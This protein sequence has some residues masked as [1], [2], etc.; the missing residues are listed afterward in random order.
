MLTYSEWKKAEK[1]G[2][3]YEVSEPYL[4]ARKWCVLVFIAPMKC[5]EYELDEIKE[6]LT[7]YLKELHKREREKVAFE[8]KITP[9]PAVAWHMS[10]S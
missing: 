3:V 5:A 6:G 2:A 1:I 4:H 9:A 7:E 8:E 10:L